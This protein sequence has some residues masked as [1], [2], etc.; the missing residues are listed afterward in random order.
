[1]DKTLRPSVLPLPS[2]IYEGISDDSEDDLPAADALPLP[3]H[4]LAISDEQDLAD[5]YELIK[6]YVDEEEEW[7]PLRD[8]E[9]QSADS[10]HAYDVISPIVKQRPLDGKMGCSV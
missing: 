1:M 2:P 9:V 4:E 5:N 10:E 8:L 6:E 7:E 3:P